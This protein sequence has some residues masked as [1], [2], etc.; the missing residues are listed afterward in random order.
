MMPI[1]RNKGMTFVEVLIS[2]AILGILL[3]ILT[4]ILSGGLF[5][6]THAG[7][8]TSDEFIAQQLMDKAINDPSFSDARVTVESANMSVPI[9]GDSALIAGRKIT[10]RVGDVKLTT[11]VAASD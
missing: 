3:V 4:G 10:V 8:K 6:I 2:L 7:K 1:Y 5:N 9:G 11:F